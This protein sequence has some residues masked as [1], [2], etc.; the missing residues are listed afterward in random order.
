M[1]RR[2]PRPVRGNAAWLL[3]RGKGRGIYGEGFGYPADGAWIDLRNTLFDATDRATVEASLVSKFSLREERSLPRCPNSLSVDLHVREHPRAPFFARPTS[4]LDSTKNNK[5]LHKYL[6]TC[7][8]G[9]SDK[10]VAPRVLAHPGARPIRRYLMDTRE[11]SAPCGH[12]PPED[13]D[14]TVEAQYS[15]LER[16]PPHACLDGWVF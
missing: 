13:R 9:V 15:G 8:M 1:A 2:G 12:A 5:I 16:L 14:D 10:K 4:S 6:I 3:L 11:S 7:K